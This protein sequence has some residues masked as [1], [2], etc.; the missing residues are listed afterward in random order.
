MSYTF[1]GIYIKEKKERNI[2][3]KKKYTIGKLAVVNSEDFAMAQKKVIENMNKHHLD[4]C[5]LTPYS[6]KEE[7]E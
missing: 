3:S 5:I 7:E 6:T 2:F 4:V 1:H